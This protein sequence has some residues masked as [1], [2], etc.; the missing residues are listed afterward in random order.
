MTKRVGWILGLSTVAALVLGSVAGVWLTT[1]LRA[2][3]WAIMAVTPIAADMV[4][5]FEW[6]ANLQR[7]APAER[8][9]G[10]AGRVRRQHV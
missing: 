9:D 4:G 10:P 1:D 2:A 7:P 3:G 8:Q 5:Y 6:Q